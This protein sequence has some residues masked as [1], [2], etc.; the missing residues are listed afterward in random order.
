MLPLKPGSVEAIGGG[1]RC[2]VLPNSS[3]VLLARRLGPLIAPDCPMHE[4]V[5]SAA[6]AAAPAREGPTG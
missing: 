3:R 4:L 1:C 6:V 2:P 5:D